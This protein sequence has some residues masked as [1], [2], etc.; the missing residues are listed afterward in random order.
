MTS[1]HQNSD[2]SIT[3]QSVTGSA[4]Y[5]EERSLE[6]GRINLYPESTFRSKAQR[7][8][9]FIYL[10][11]KSKGLCIIVESNTFASSSLYNFQAGKVESK[12]KLQAKFLV[13]LE[14]KELILFG[15]SLATFSILENDFVSCWRLRKVWD[16]L[17]VSHDTWETR[18]IN[19]MGRFLLLSTLKW[20]KT[21]IQQFWDADSQLGRIPL[22]KLF[23]YVFTLTIHRLPDDVLRTKVWNRTNSPLGYLGKWREDQRF[24]D[25]RWCQSGMTSWVR[26]NYCNWVT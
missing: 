8:C 2:T 9:Y 12:G 22:S 20:Q 5:V 16:I 11:R 26:Y 1:C 6:G 3:S 23:Y 10:W 21:L 25:V 7:S 18:N 19:S 24:M 4:C 15:L 17:V 13:C 14:A